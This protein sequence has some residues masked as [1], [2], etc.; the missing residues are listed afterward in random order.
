MYLTDEQKAELARLLQDDSMLN[1]ISEDFNKILFLDI[2]DYHNMDF[3]IQDIEERDNKTYNKDS[4]S[5]YEEESDERTWAIWDLIKHK[6]VEIFCE[7]IKYIKNSHMEL[8]LE[9][10]K[11]DAKKK[12]EGL[13]TDLAKNIIVNNN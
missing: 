3:Y 11:E 7:K 8:D 5:A 2:D 9:Y 4:L 6:D 12:L 1:L 13:N 10:F